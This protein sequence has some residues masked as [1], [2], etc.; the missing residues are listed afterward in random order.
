M[1]FYKTGPTPSTWWG[2]LMTSADSGATWSQ[3]KRLP[4]GI[5][6]PVKNKPMQLDD[7][8][9]VCP[10]R[11]EHDG[12][13]LHLEFTTDLGQTWTR[14]EP[15]NDG[16]DKGAIQPSLLFHPDGRWQMLAR[17][18][19]GM[20]YIWTSWSDDRG[21]TW[22]ALDSTGLPNPSS[23]IDAV[24]LTDGR[25]LLVYNH[26]QRPHPMADIGTSRGRLNVAVSDDGQRWQAALVL[27]Q[28][29]H[30][31]SYPAVIQTGDDMVHI[32]YTWKRQR[33]KHVVIDPAQLKLK[34]IMD[35]V[36]PE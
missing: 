32:T 21:K 13:R 29:P 8:T 2:M 10:S 12:W 24:T 25:Q 16:R 19:C 30:E 28:S 3:P 33:I 26:R 5:I 15:L 6:G 35:G 17:D 20:G 9:I 34:P 31:Y 11:T 1:L 36:W 22:S 23:G 14:S 27:E 4:D 18:R 7:G